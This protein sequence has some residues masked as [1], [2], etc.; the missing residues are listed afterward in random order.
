MHVVLAVEELN[1]IHGGVERT[2]V[3]LANSLIKKS[4]RVTILTFE[5]AF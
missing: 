1:G 4:H 3:N 2:V 5:N